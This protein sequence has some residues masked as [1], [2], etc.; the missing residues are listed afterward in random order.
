VR[1]T[2]DSKQP[3]EIVFEDDYIIVL[4]KKAKLLIQ[5]TKKERYTLTYA[6]NQYLNEKKERAIPCHRLDRETTG[7]IIY[8]KD[9]VVGRRVME[10]FKRREIKKRYIAFVKG[11]LKKKKG[12]LEGYILDREGREHKERPKKAKTFYQVRREFGNFSVVELEPL[13][14]RT[15]QL[16]IQLAKLGNPIL[17]ERKYAFRRDFK[18]N[19]RRLALHAFYISFIHPVSKERVNLKIDLPQDMKDFLLKLTNELEL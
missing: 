12:V 9:R 11:K 14:G 5:P 3:F 17:G 16:R 4:N 19:F 15:N 10:Q 1:D 8:V 7:L 6:L 2:T 13:T 18:V